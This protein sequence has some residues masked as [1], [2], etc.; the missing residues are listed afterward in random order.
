MATLTDSVIA[1]GGKVIGIIPQF[2]VDK[3]W[4]HPALTETIITSGMHPRKQLMAQKSNACI[5]LPGGIGTLEELLEIIAW[6]QLGLYSQT[7]VILNTNNYYSDLFSLL[8]RAEKE[9]FIPEKTD[10]LWLIAQTP[11]DAIEIILDFP[12]KGNL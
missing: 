11:Q 9:R 6:K 4:I 3:A 7:V 1:N 2:M 8:N 10:N 5:A 12:P